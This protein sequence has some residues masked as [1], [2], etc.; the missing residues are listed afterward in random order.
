MTTF[1]CLNLTR[2]VTSD[3]F[4]F[5]QRN[6]F[7]VHEDDYIW[8]LKGIIIIII[9]IIIIYY[10]HIFPEYGPSIAMTLLY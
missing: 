9:I 7:F 2:L 1:F 10:S 6:D 4:I 5:W 8:E 3:S